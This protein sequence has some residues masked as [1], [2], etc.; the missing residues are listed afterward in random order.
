VRLTAFDI[1]GRRVRTLWD[2]PRDAGVHRIAWDG[3][4]DAGL[5]V[6]PGLYWMALEA[7]RVRSTRRVVR[8]R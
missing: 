5:S 7:D 2:G 3:R 4:N 1:A 8:L 6:A